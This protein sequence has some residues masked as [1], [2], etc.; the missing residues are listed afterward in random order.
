MNTLGIEPVRQ[1]TLQSICQQVLRFFNWKIV[2]RFANVAK[3]IVVGAPHTSNWD[4][5]L[6]LLL[7]GATGED[8]HWIGKDSLF[9]WPLGGL[10]KRLGGIPVNRRASSNFVDQMVEKFGEYER[11]KIAISPEGT[12]GKTKNWKTGFYYMAVGAKVPIQLVSIDYAIRTLEI[13]PLLWP[14]GELQQD[15]EAIRNFYTGK[16]GKHPK[17]QGEIIPTLEE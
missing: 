13:G 16:A 15:F 7:K 12:R 5:F 3:S 17:K 2:G 6:M 8:L 14:T 10:M 1:T 9:R 11:I 4:F